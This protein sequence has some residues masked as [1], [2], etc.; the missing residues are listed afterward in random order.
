MNKIGA[1]LSHLHEAETALAGEFRKVAQRQAADHGTHYV[2]LSLAD[3]CDQHAE[4][5]RAIASHFGENLSEPRHSAAVAAA[6]ETVRH[7]SSELWGRRP[8]SGLLLLRDL[9][10]LYLMAEEAD[11]DWTLLG[12]V[13]QAVRSQELVDDVTALHEQTLTQLKWL[14]TRMKETAPQVLTVSD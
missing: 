4:R 1:L 14:K 5:L 10:R 13:A 8:S 9:R 3:Q 6:M 7:K 11:I 12:Q 2:C